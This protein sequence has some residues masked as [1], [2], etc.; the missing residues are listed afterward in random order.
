MFD[1]YSRINKRGQI[2]R[3]KPLD[4]C[5]GQGREVPGVLP[6]IFF[7]THQGVQTKATFGLSK[8]NRNECDMACNLAQFLVKYLTLKERF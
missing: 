2:G 7:W 8:I 1:F 5:S 3:A 6:H 4:H